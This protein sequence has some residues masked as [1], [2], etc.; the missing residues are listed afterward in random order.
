MLELERAKMSCVS[1]PLALTPSNSCHLT[2]PQTHHVSY[3]AYMPEYE[4][5]IK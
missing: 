4:A 1:K 2:N 5:T 3:V